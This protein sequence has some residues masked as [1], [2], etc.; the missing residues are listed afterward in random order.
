MAQKSQPRAGSLQFWPRKKARKFIPS[1][2]WK[3]ISSE[4]Q[5]LMGVIAYKVGMDS[6]LIKDSTPNSLTKEKKII[7]PVSIL[8]IPGIKI[9]SVRFYKNNK[10]MKDVIVSDDKELIKKVKL[11]KQ[12]KQLLEKVGKMDNIKDYEDIGVIAYSLAKKTGIKK[13][14]DLAE[15]ALSGSIEEK[16]NFVK[17]NIG[18]EILGSEILKDVNLVDV[19]G[20]TKGK[21]IQGPVKRFGIKL[22]SHKSEK[23]QRRPGSLGPW[24]PAH[25]MFRAPM[26]GQLGLFTRI[27]YN[28]KIVS[29]GKGEEINK[30]QGFEH[31]GK[32]NSEYILLKGSVQGNEKRQLLLTL[33]LRKTKKQLK[34]KYEFLGLK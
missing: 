27:Q 19:R 6:A 28:C 16:L 20:L 3:I 33:P 5:G 21:G 7:I 12:N 9:F 10:V 13:T 17:E 26:S 34:K 11:P 8:E 22:K 14:P 24:H 1:V 23:G 18:K 31:Y 4:K 30:K 32:I 15:I 25:I 29:L 2:N